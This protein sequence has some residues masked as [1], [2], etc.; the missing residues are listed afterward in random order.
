MA[1]SQDDL[2]TIIQAVWTYFKEHGIAL[3]QNIILAPTDEAG[4]AQIKIVALKDDGTTQAAGILNLEAIL[5]QYG[6]DVEAAKDDVIQAL[7][8]KESELENAL[9]TYVEDLIEDDINPLVTQAESAKNT[10]LSYK[11]AAEDSLE[12]IE[13]L[14]AQIETIASQS[15]QGAYITLDGVLYTISHVM[16][17]G[18][19]TSTLTEVVQS[20]SDGSDTQETA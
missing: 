15:S 5:E 11:N 2:N 4:W 16:K 6:G 20:G 13:D 8:D 18:I 14:K 17:D 1:V 12:E 19:L 3:D 9:D 10:T 7:T